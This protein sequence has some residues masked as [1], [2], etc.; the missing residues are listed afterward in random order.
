MDECLPARIAGALP[1]HRRSA[2]ATHTPET[3]DLETFDFTGWDIALFAIGLRATKTSPPRPA[4]AGCGVIDNSSALTA[5]PS[6]RAADVPEVKPTP[7]PAIRRKHHRQ[8]QLL[9]AAKMVV[10]L[11]PPHDPRGDQAG[12]V[13]TYQFVLRAQE[14]ISDELWTRTRRLRPGQ[15]VAHQEVHKQNRLQRHCPIIHVSS[16]TAP[17]KEKVR[18]WSPEKQED[19]SIPSDQSN[20]RPACA[21]PVFVGHSERSTSSVEDCLGRHEARDIHARVPAC[22]VHRQARSK[23]RYVNALECVAITPPSQ[24]EPAKEQDDRQNAKYLGRV[25]TTSA[26]R[27]AN[28]V[29]NRR[30]FGHPV[31]RSLTLRPTS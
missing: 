5:S 24:P 31:R 8:P 23:T 10:A 28:A 13:L 27:G 6:R 21:G 4:A 19:V 20:A 26:G 7:S 1:R 18:R 30:R 22:M 16:T 11:K 12:G 29:Q 3:Q 17:P 15:E 2:S 14:G 9:N 25:R